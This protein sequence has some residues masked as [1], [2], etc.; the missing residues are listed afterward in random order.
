MTA[1]TAKERRI[2]LEAKMKAH[3]KTVD[4]LTA[5]TTRLALDLSAAKAEE[6]REGWKQVHVKR[7]NTL[8]ETARN[9]LVEAGELGAEHGIDFTFDGPR[10]KLDFNVRWMS[11]DCYGTQRWYDQGYNRQRDGEQS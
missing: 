11:S 9:A 2:A 3:Q 7:I 1:T 8:L 4:E 10:D 5:Q 6:E